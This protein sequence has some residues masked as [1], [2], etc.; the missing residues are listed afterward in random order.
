MFDGTTIM[1][2]IISGGGGYRFNATTNTEGLYAG[3]SGG[4]NGS[5]GNTI[6]NL[7]QYMYG[8]RGG[9]GLLTDGLY[10]GGKSFL[11][12]G[13][14]IGSGGFGGGTSSTTYYVWNGLGW[15]PIGEFG[16]G[17][18]YSGGGG[19]G[20]GSYNTGDGKVIISKVN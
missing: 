11:N 16:A 9:G 4:N 6:A 17:G 18:G 5:G 14:G 19:G 10:N 3:T 20:G 2:L 8:S 12:G 1:P 15:N 13:Q 7:S